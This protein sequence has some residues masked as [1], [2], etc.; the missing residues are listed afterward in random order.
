M[1]LSI[2]CYFLIVNWGVVIKQLFKKFLRNLLGGVLASRESTG[3][4][5]GVK[6]LV[7]AAYRFHILL[8]LFLLS[9]V[10]KKIIC[11]YQVI[12]YVSV[13]VGGFFHFYGEA[14]VHAN[15]I[16]VVVVGQENL[17]TEVLHISVRRLCGRLFCIYVFEHALKNE[18]EGAWYVSCNISIIGTCFYE[19]SNFSYLIAGVRVVLGSSINSK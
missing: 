1:C 5:H 16:R 4:S 10:Q 11:C 17:K 7:S 2:Y 8:R 12:I 19:L 14:Q 3:R 9:S 6:M 15:G 13:F 18:V